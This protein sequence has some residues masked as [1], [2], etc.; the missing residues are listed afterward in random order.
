MNA[1]RRR[2]RPC[3]GGSRVVSG[4]GRWRPGARADGR[5]RRGPDGACVSRLAGGRRARHRYRARTTARG[6]RGAPGATRTAVRS[7]GARRGRR[8]TVQTVHPRDITPW[9]RPRPLRRRRERTRRRRVAGRLGA[10]GWVSPAGRLSPRLDGAVAAFHLPRWL[11][12]ADP[13]R[14]GRWPRLLGDTGGVPWGESALDAAVPPGQFVPR[15]LPRLG[16][17]PGQ[18]VPRLL[19]R[20]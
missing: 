12:S 19:P 8:R 20:L 15:L 2:T 1:R 18:F 5:T 3:R 7:R 4:R 14:L 9:K 10:R 17:P 11:V 13:Q 6:A 16:T